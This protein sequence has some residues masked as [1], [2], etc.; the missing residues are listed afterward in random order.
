[1]KPRQIHYRGGH[2]KCVV[3]ELRLEGWDLLLHEHVYSSTLQANRLT[4]ASEM[5]TSTK[6]SPTKIKHRRCSYVIGGTE[7]CRNTS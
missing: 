6:K 4:A 7:V 2:D 3:R 1:M 5:T